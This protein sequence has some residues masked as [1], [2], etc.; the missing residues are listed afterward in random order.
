VRD[1]T[2]GHPLSPDS[3]LT[4]QFI[5]LLGG[6]GGGIVLQTEVAISASALLVFASNTAIIGAYHVFMALSRMDFFPA[7]VLNRNKLRD[8]P[9]WAITLATGI[10][11]VVLILVLGNITLL[12]DM[13]AFGLLGAFS[14][15][16]LGLDLVRYRERKD[17]RA[18]TSSL[19]AAYLENANDS[20]RSNSASDVTS[21]PT[22]KQAAT[23]DQDRLAGIS[24]SQGDTATRS[25]SQTPRITLWSTIDFWLGILTTILVIAAWSTNLVTKLPATV[26]GGSVA[27]VGMI[28][29]YVN[30]R[31]QKREGRVPVTTVMTTGVEGRLPGSTLAV[32]TSGNGHNDAVIRA[33]INNADGHPVVFLYVSDRKPIARRPD[34]FEVVDPY[35]DDPQAKEY[36]GRAEH[37]AQQAKIPARRY[38]YRQQEPGTVARVWQAVHPHDTV[39]AAENTSQFEDIN[40]DRIRYELTSSGKV[41]HMLKQW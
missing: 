10:P 27:S 11:I 14:L 26:F 35:I 28:V 29:A 25:S 1:P 33:A 22:S 20:V 16:C 32:L 21:S 23:T 34:L 39:I 6:Y 37:A 2:T 38:V 41:A 13:Y 24:R 8:T 15:T 9:H 30:Y 4:T 5:S 31:S 17:I 40:P 12:G 3:V 19:P 7:F 18:R 36:F